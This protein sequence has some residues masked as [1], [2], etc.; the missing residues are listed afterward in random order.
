M[1]CQPAYRVKRPPAIIP[2]VA[3]PAP[4]P[5]QIPSAL[6]RS[7]PSSNMF[8]TIDRAAGSMIAAPMPWTARAPIMKPA[9]V[10]SAAASDAALNSPSPSI[11]MRRRPSRSA[12]R[13]PRSKNPPN[14]SAYAVTTHCRLVWEKCRSR[15]I[16]GS[17]TLTIVRSMTVM[18][19]AT[20]SSANARQR[21]IWDDCDIIR[22]P[23]VSP[24]VLAASQRTSQHRRPIWTAA[25]R[26]RERSAREALPVSLREP[27]AVFAREPLPS[28]GVER[29]QAPVQ[30]GP[31]DRVGAERDRSLVRARGGHRVA[32]S[33]EQ[34]GVCRVQRLVAL[35]RRVGQQRLEQLEPGLGPTANPTA[36]ARFSSTIGEGAISPSAPYSSAICSQSVVPVSAPRTCTAV[37]AACSWYWPGRRNRIARSSASSPSPSRSRSHRER[38]CSSSA[39]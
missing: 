17:E 30:L 5:P 6:L 27:R 20:A 7:A 25:A 19:N 39:R 9:P 4:S 29:R 24:P 8:I 32:G 10:A 28:V 14:V 2:T 37:I 1:Y 33:P 31:L 36:A 21:L 18:K 3:P 22:P 15:P 26:N 11:R 12:A 16:V 34:V 38:F 35:E 13:P 23:V